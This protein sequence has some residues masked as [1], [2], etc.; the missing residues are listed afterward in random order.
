ME[1]NGNQIKPKRSRLPLYVVVFLFICA[2]ISAGYLLTTE[3]GKPAKPPTPNK[4]I[5]INSEDKATP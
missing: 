5:Q 4:T 3:F 2:V 1:M